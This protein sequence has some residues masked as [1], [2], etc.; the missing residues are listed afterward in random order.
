ML[1]FSI[2]FLTSL[3]R[4]CIL[5]TSIKDVNVNSLERF[6]GNHFEG[7]SMSHERIYFVDPLSLFASVW[8]WPCWIRIEIFFTVAFAFLLFS[9][10]V[11]SATQVLVL[12][13]R[14]LADISKCCLALQDLISDTKNSVDSV[15]IIYFDQFWNKRYPKF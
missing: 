9:F 1:S 8:Y 5:N 6:Y 15:K 12:L 2:I 7:S 13:F 11:R 14:R 4:N 3:A 10:L